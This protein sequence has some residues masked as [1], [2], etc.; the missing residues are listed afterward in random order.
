[1]LPVACVAA[2]HTPPA[3]THQVQHCHDSYHG[4]R[5]SRVIL[6]DLYVDELGSRAHNLGL[7]AARIKSTPEYFTLHLIEGPARSLIVLCTGAL[8]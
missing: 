3:G 4:R 6:R 2:V 5:S 8:T 1:M 7:Q